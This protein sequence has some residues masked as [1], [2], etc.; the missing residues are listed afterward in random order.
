[1]NT[2]YM[3]IVAAMAVMLIGATAL[4]TEDAFADK[5]RHDDKKKGGYEKSQAVSQVN[6]CGNGGER[7]GHNEMS[8]MT[9]PI[10]GGAEN[11]GCQNTASQI[12]GDYNSAALASEQIF[13]D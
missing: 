7:R 11:V 1:M 13:D 5:K 4:A 2:K 10:E 3:F 6:D 9:D 12:Q 8:T